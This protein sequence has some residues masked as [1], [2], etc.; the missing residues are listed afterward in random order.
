VIH[1]KQQKQRN[2][3]TNHPNNTSIQ[4]YTAKNI[5]TNNDNLS[6][7]NHKKQQKRQT[8]LV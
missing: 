3:K 8:K 6:S 7:R 2:T 1:T 5:K 4:T